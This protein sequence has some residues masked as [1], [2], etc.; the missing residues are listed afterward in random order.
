MYRRVNQCAS[1]NQLAVAIVRY[2]CVSAIEP[3]LYTTPLAHS[4]TC[5]RNGGDG[6]ERFTLSAGFPP[7]EVLQASDSLVD[8]GLVGAAIVQKSC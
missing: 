2:F 8:A 7:R 6:S 3:Y 5:S 1:V 4:S